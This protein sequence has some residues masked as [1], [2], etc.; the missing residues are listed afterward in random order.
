[1]ATNH[2]IVFCYFIINEFSYFDKC[3]C[4]FSFATIVQCPDIIIYAIRAV[5]LIIASSSIFIPRK[6]MT[7]RELTSNSVS[8]PWLYPL[9]WS[10]VCFIHFCRW[11]CFISR[12]TSLLCYLYHCAFLWYKVLLVPYCTAHISL[13]RTTA[14]Y[15][16]LICCARYT[17]VPFFK[18]L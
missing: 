9:S 2:S 11:L 16:R 7:N 8:I 1:M 4:R 18:I 12:G 3:W 14:N 10:S 17:R 6:W 5:R 13:R 15:L